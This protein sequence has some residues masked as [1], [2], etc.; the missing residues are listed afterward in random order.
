MRV[1]NTE[2]T[3]TGDLASLVSWEKSGGA[4]HVA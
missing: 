2:Q 1:A 3:L 4:F